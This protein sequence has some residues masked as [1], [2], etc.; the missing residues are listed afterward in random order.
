[1]MLRAILLLAACA[2]LAACQDRQDPPPP[3]AAA[4][5][6]VA[7]SSGSVGTTGGRLPDI[8]GYPAQSPNR[9]SGRN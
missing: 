5:P 4:Q 7:P 1:M 9:P 2:G 6:N 8:G 3:P